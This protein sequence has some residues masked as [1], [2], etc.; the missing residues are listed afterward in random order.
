MPPV[1]RRPHLTTSLT[2]SPCGLGPEDRE[3]YLTLALTPGVGPERLASLLT[4][5]GSPGGAL[6]APFAFL[7]AI[8]G[9]SSNCARAIQAAP[10]DAGQRL[11]KAVE[12][13][14]GRALLPFDAEFPALLHDIPAPPPFLIATGRFELLQRTAVAIVGSRD[15]S[16]YGGEV[17]RQ[18]AL[19][20]AMAGIVVVSGLARGLDAVAHWAA[21]DAGGG[22]IAVLGNGIDVVYPRANQRLSDAIRRD[23]LLVS[24]F[25]PGERPTPGS[26]PRRNRL[27]SGLARV[28]VLI[29]ASVRSGALITAEAALAQGREVMVVPGPITA[30][31]AEGTNGLLRD[32]ATPLTHP[33]DV[34]RYYPEVDE[35]R[36]NRDQPDGP[37]GRIL[38]AL[39]LGALHVDELAGTLGLPSGKLLGLLGAMELTGMVR[40]DPPLTFSIDPLVATGPP[41]RG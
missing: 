1:P 38:T 24:E 20:A 27:I 9:I 29:E 21:L 19:S 33:S 25:L 32:G 6:M 12:Q 31:T 39:R 26:F 8:P 2:S 40:Q 23:G 28:T 18:V 30:V 10:R 35:V 5:F 41:V 22:T 7:C 36:S 17:C 13:S 4:A 34:L 15:H 37:Q 14:G 16:R 3:S 11:L